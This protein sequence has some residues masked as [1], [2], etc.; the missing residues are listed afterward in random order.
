MKNFKISLIDQ[1][2]KE[3]ATKMEAGLKEYELSYDIH[4]DY[5]PFALELFN[6]NNET[7]GV[8]EAFSSYSSIHIKDLWIE[9]SYR[10]QGY[11]KYLIIE[12]ERLFKG[13]GF[14]NINLVTCAFQAPE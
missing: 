8:L 6:E 10:N 13:Q 12:L 7:I 1:V 11:G 4:V 2:S 14:N 9:K 3:T 5:K